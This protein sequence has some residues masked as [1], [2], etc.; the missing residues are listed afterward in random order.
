MALFIKLNNGNELVINELNK[1]LVFYQGKL[2]NT[3]EN[4]ETFII[5][6]HH[7]YSFQGKEIVVV[8]ADDILSLK[9]MK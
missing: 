6:S 2:K 7:L 1:I 8:R 9:F 4:F 3:F 5:N